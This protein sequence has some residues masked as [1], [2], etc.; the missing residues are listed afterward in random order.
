M[1][2]ELENDVIK[3][4]PK[5]ISNETKNEILSSMFIL[6]YDTIDKVSI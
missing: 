1:V 5:Y 2:K 6:K 4:Q 3:L